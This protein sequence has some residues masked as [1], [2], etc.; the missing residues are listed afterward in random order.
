M[1]LYQMINYREKKC[2]HCNL[3]SNVMT[4]RFQKCFGATVLVCTK[5]KNHMDYSLNTQQHHS[6]VVYS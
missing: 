4:F 5:H 3:S 6:L 2:L 1:S